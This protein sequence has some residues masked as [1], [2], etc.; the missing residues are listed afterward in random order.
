MEIHRSSLFT[1]RSIL[2]GAA[3]AAPAAAIRTPATYVDDFGARGDDRS[4]DSAAIQ[5]AI[6]AWGKRGGT[7]VFGQNRHYFLGSYR[8]YQTVLRVTGVTDAAI[9][10]NGATLRTTS[11]A[12]GAQ[13]FLFRLSGYRNLTIRNL[14]AWDDGTDLGVNWRGLYAFAPDGNGPLCRNL[15]LRNVVVHDAVAFLYAG[16][17]AGGRIEGIDISACRALRCYYGLVFEENGDDVT[18]H[19]ETVNCRR[20]YF[21]YGVARHRIRLAVYHDGKALGAEACCLIKRYQQDTSD[22]D[23]ELR[24]RGPALPFRYAVKLEHQPTLATSSSTIRNVRAF[25]DLAKAWRASDPVVPFGL[26][27]YSGTEEERGVTR[28]RWQD[29]VLAGRFPAGLRQLVDV[30]ATPFIRD[31][32][33]LPRGP[34]AD[35]PGFIV[36][37]R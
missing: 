4:D 22:I 23:L 35:P 18:A 29:V 20:S 36:T 16:G 28:N 17:T 33:T 25:V 15:V 24:L 14:K 7:L 10:G 5:H 1:R 9:D 30:R 13:T 31:R 34:W 32:M 19:L 8:G 37:R 11:T 26:S 3:L 6:E 2:A 12:P 21:P 27:S